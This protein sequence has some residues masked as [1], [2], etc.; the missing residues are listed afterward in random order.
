[1][2]QIMFETFKVPGLYIADTTSLPLY[3]AGKYNG[4]VVELGDGSS[5]FASILDGV[6]SACI[7]LDLGGRDLTKYLAKLLIETGHIFSNSGEL[8]IVKS[9]KEKKCYVAF[10]YIEELKT[11]ELDDYELPDG[12]HVMLKQQR[13]RCPEALFHPILVDKAENGIAQTCFDLI[14]KND[15]DKR[16]DLCNFIYLSGGVSRFGG[17]KERFEKEIKAL[18][19]E[20]IKEEIKVTAAPTKFEVWIGGFILS[21]MS[22]FE[23]K[24]ITKAEYEESGMNI[25]LKKC[26]F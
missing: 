8:E 21:K 4:V 10:N 3:S 12:N 14:Q 17:L 13:I 16:K 11:V 15:I 25:V 1:M 19:P 20:S 6:P 5:Q 23:S 18:A 22:S 7:R 26:P 24:W 9:L 2:A